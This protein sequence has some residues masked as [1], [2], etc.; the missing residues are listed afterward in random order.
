MNKNQTSLSQHHQLKNWNRNYFIDL[1][2]NPSSGTIAST[3]FTRIRQNFEL[4]TLKTNSKGVLAISNSN[5][6]HSSSPQ[7]NLI[8]NIK[9]SQ[10]LSP[11][12]DLS[13]TK[14]SQNNTNIPPLNKIRVIKQNRNIKSYDFL[15][16]KEKINDFRQM[17]TKTQLS[18]IIRKKQNSA[19]KINRG[20]QKSRSLAK[21]DFLKTITSCLEIRDKN[22][23]ILEI[24]DKDEEEK[25]GNLVNSG[26]FL[27]FQQ[28]AQNKI[29]RI[30]RVYSENF[31][32]GENKAE[33]KEILMDLMKFLYQE[34]LKLLKLYEIFLTKNRNE[35]MPETENSL[36][37]I[38][39][40]LVSNESSNLLAGLEILMKIHSP[41]NSE[42]RIK[43]E[44]INEEYYKE[45]KMIFNH[46]LYETETQIFQTVLS[47]LD[48]TFKSFE[49]IIEDLLNKNESLTNEVSSFHVLLSSNIL[50]NKL[51]TKELLEQKP[52]FS[53]F[54]EKSG[55][56]NYLELISN[57]NDMMVKNLK[58]LTEENDELQK[59]VTQFRR[60][61]LNQD[62]SP[63]R[64]QTKK[65]K[66]TE[67][68]TQVAYHDL[69]KIAKEETTGIQ[70]ILR[71]STA[72]YKFKDDDLLSI[73]NLVLSEKIIEDYKVIQE[74]NKIEPLGQFLQGFFLLHM[75]NPEITNLILRDFLLNLRDNC[76][77]NLRYSL[78]LE[79][80]GV[81]FDNAKNEIP[82]PF[83]EIEVKKLGGKKE[84]RKIFYSSS[85]SCKILLKTAYLIRYNAKIEDND[86][87]GPLFPGVNS[88]ADIQKL[89]ILT[90]ILK[91]ILSDEG[92]TDPEIQEE[93]L[94]NFQ[95]FSTKIKLPIFAS[96]GGINNNRKSSIGMS[97]AQNRRTSS[98]P[99]TETMLKYDYFMKFVLD[100]F[101]EE[102]QQKMEHFSI[103]LKLM[104]NSRNPGKVFIEDFRAV[105]MKIIGNVSN[106]MIGKLYEKFVELNFERQIKN[107]TEISEILA[108]EILEMVRFDEFYI[109]ENDQNIKSKS[110]P[111]N[112]LIFAK[113]E[114]D[115]PAEGIFIY[116][117]NN[118]ENYKSWNLLDK[119]KDLF[120]IANFD[121][122]DSLCF[123]N[124]IYDYIRETIKE[125]E[126]KNDSLYTYHEIWKKEFY[127]LPMFQ[128][129]RNLKKMSTMFLSWDRLDLIQK[130]QMNWNL[131]KLISDAILIKSRKEV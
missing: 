45:F 124:L 97:L 48:N 118:P 34:I 32:R 6:H 24:L 120:T 117:Q 38:R 113:R 98:M 8:S 35:K 66:T 83:H 106:S 46:F 2:E 126:D 76:E 100:F 52:K 88:D 31:E 79:L 21:E 90:G 73:I 60:T 112:L 10:I 123:V 11:S 72:Y 26:N 44:E 82:P 111:Q 91:E 103:L 54:D 67:K 12:D 122:V 19:Q 13:K 101:A 131:I 78:F 116:N 14:K 108:K 3:L 96:T 41:Y 107:Y 36:K 84:F 15:G 49:S 93:I 16:E 68:S 104:E 119:S 77:K 29:R 47:K 64:K 53:E 130:I 85:Y 55:K 125:N 129:L 128:G 51:E 57:Y 114:N 43:L 95:I 87:Y 71:K 40:S 109:S 62:D 94:K 33:G 9:D 37:N 99:S 39:Y 65:P 7:S 80:C 50:I 63:R 18:E 23:Y 17:T 58:R 115:K 70:R 69:T 92:I 127:K 42:H 1:N 4:K 59:Q 86:P 89:K 74:K 30:E 61:T 105:I 81:E 75:G 25:L 27:E 56:G 22:S 28:T 102:F 20:V 121:I 110:K 5:L